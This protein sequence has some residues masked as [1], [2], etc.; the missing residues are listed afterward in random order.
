[1]LV[2]PDLG[3]CGVSRFWAEEEPG[4]RPKA[5]LQLFP[6]LREAKEAGTGEELPGTPGEVW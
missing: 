5:S 6:E 1:M 4:Q 3:P 2:L